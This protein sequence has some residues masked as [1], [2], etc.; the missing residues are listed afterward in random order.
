MGKGKT[1]IN[2]FGFFYFLVRALFP[3]IWCVINADAVNGEIDIDQL[4]TGSN[5]DCCANADTRIKEM[6]RKV[7]IVEAK[8][9]KLYE[10]FLSW[11]LYTV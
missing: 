9:Y 6:L 7:L 4:N 11:L 5:F 3:A 10:I 2:F 1:I 8:F